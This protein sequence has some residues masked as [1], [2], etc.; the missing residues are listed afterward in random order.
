MVNLALGGRRP[1]TSL[2]WIWT[3][4]GNRLRS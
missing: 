2:G 3:A 4:A 1:A